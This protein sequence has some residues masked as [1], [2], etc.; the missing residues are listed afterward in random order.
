MKQIYLFAAMLLTT[1]GLSAQNYGTSTSTGTSSPYEYSTA[2]TTVLSVTS[3]DVLSSWQTIPF[4]F[5]F[6]GQAVTGYYASDNGYITFDNG[7]LTSVPTNTSIPSAGGPNNAIYAFW[8]DLNIISGSGSTDKVTSFTYGTAPHR[9][10]VIQWFSVTP[11]S[12]SGFIYA[13]IRLYECGD[14]DIVH[15]F[16]NASGMTATVGCENATGSTGLQVAGS[17][18]MTYPSVGSLP[19]D[20]VVYSFFWDQIGY[21]MAVVELDFDGTVAI[22]TN[23]ISGRVANNAGTAVTS[24]DLN[25]SINGGA[26]QTMS[27]TNVVA[28]LGG[29]YSFNHSIPWTVSTGGLSFDLCVWADNING[30]NVDERTCND[31]I[32]MNL[33][34]RT[35]NS[36]TRTVLL[37]EFT[38]TWCGWCPDG[39]IVYED[40]IAANPNDVVVV[41]VH[42]GDAMEF[43]DGIRSGFNVS[44]YPNGM[45]DRK[46]FAGEVDEPHSRGAWDA[47]VQSQI[48]S[49]TP[50]D[51]SISHV[52]DS[53]SR[54]ITLNVTSVF[55]DY[56]AGDMRFVAMIVEDSIVGTGTGYNQVNYLN[57]SAGHPYFGAGDPIVG[58]VHNHVLRALPG[59]AYGNSGIIPS[60][61]SPT[62]QYTETFTYTL[63]STMDATKIKL[64]G[65][66][67]YYGTEVGESEVM[68]VAQMDLVFQ[69]NTA[70]SY[71]PQVEDFK[72][73]PNP[74]NNL[75]NF[76]FE[77]LKENDTRVAIYD[78]YGKLIDV[79]NQSTLSAG[80]QNIAYDV[81]NLASG[82]YYVSVT[83]EGSATYTE[84]FVVSK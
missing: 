71:I 77:L 65:F 32:C 37:E 49:Y 3:S 74:A 22:G 43:T 47:N 39:V 23:I 31:Q 82:V 53:S 2:G 5:D 55:T 30:V 50:A 70:I 48:G 54:Q 19:D 16:G 27:I 25:Y 63:P 35:G 4:S 14:F 33:F 79:I 58:F 15:N 11:I 66:V 21:D 7:A 68:D 13:A 76:S 78:A 18:N 24:F 46:V 59:G 29:T 45:V 26:T 44:A 80:T 64:V 84:R 41:S 9:V 40:I 73:Y 20:D 72:A 62:D 17:P 57:T 38:G 75:I 1:L 83:T 8:D 60:T 52:Y 56:A 34:S 69:G 28:A 81:R 42:D 67:A 10:H 12:G 6:Y 61:V 36:G 51:V